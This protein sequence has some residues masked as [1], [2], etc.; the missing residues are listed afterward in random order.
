[1]VRRNTAYACTVGLAALLVAVSPSCGSRQQ[2]S[3]PPSSGKL[4][5]GAGWVS[6]PAV[7][8][9]WEWSHIS[10]Q[11][12]VRR[13]EVERWNVAVAGTQVTGSYERS[14]TFLS[15]DGV[16]FDCNQNLTYE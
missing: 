15:T 5:P 1:M 7:A 6:A 3:T 14:V 16:P 13:I 4:P 11:D 12:D 2:R 8:G 10:E 9:D